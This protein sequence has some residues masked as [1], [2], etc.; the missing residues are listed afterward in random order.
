MCNKIVAVL[1]ERNHLSTSLT[2]AG[3]ASADIELSH[4]MQTSFRVTEDFDAL[5]DAAKAQQWSP[6][7]SE[8]LPEVFTWEDW[9]EANGGNID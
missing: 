3:F 8:G 5:T 4:V 7:R 9:Q 2:M 1:S 6:K